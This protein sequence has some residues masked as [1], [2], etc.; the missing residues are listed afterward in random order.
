MMMVMMMPL[1]EG[2]EVAGTVLTQCLG[3]GLRRDSGDRRE[4]DAFDRPPGSTCTGKEIGSSYRS[5]KFRG[6]F[7]DTPFKT[8][9][10]TKKLNMKMV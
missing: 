6:A 3:P 8:I 10:N 1:F 2:V 4:N 9:G 7:F 5:M